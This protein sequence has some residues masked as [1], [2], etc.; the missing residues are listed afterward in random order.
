MEKPQFI[1][2]LRAGEKI[3]FQGE[4]VTFEGYDNIDSMYWDAVIAAE[5]LRDETMTKSPVNA[6]MLKIARDKGAN[7]LT[8]TQIRVYG[9]EFESSHHVYNIA[10]TL[11]IGMP[12]EGEGRYRK[13]FKNRPVMELKNNT[14][15]KVN[16]NVQR[17]NP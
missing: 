15:G 14:T 1:Y 17:L 12:A 8:N 5:K 13:V 9:G 16:A 2:N 10:G 6:D 7:L 4:K 11:Y 3:D